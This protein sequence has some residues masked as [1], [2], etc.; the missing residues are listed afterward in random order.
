[1]KISIKFV[2]QD[3]W[4]GVYWK[5][6]KRNPFLMKWEWNEY[7]DG[8]VGFYEETQNLTIFI[9]MIPM[10]PIIIKITRVTKVYR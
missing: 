9:C 8:L 1:M 2:P 6:E 7:S 3:L 4:I 10:F 5:Y